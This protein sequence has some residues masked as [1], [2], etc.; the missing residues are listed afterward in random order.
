MSERAW[1][2]LALALLAAVAVFWW[3]DCHRPRRTELVGRADRAGAADRDTR[4]PGAASTRRAAGGRP[5]VPGVDND[6]PW[7]EDPE[8]APP[9][10]P[11]WREQAAQHWAVRFLTPH[12]GESLLEYRDRVVPVA[13]LA[14]APQRARVDRQRQSF[15]A[16]AALDPEQEQALETAVRQAAYDIQDMVMQGVLSGELHPARTK[17][18]SAVAF[19][20]DVLDVLDRANREFRGA[21]SDE[22]LEILDQ[23]SFDVVDYLVFSTRWEDVLGV[24]E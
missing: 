23:S 1:R 18:A 13:Q 9:P 19:A 7:P 3:R 15:A 10:P 17:P 5:A 11:D 20:R 6:E 14:V 22:Q 4:G 24:V 12:P 8:D 2:Y 16:E 21:L